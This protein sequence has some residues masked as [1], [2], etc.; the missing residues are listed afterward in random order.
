MKFYTKLVA[1]LLVT[2][3]LSACNKEENTELGSSST[4]SGEQKYVTAY[5][6]DSYDFAKKEQSGQYRVDLTDKVELS[7]NTEIKV[8]SLELLTSDSD[9][10][11]LSQDDSSF[12]ITTD[13][14]KVCDYEYFINSTDSNAELVGKISG[15]SRV[16]V[17]DDV[18]QAEL[19]PFGYVAYQGQEA[20]I[21]VEKELNK[22]G[23]FTDLDGYTLDTAVLSTSST[24]QVQL[25]T[26]NNIIEYTPAPGFLG[27]EPIMYSMKNANGD[28]LA[29]TVIA[30]VADEVKAG[31]DIQDTIV[32]KEPVLVSEST[33]V[34]L[35]PYVTNSDDDWQL[36]YVNSFDAMVNLTNPEDLQNKAFDFVAEHIGDFYVNAVVTDHHGGFDVSLIRLSVQ[37][38]NSAAT[39]NDIIQD[40][41]LFKAPL[42]LSEAQ[43]QG[44]IFASANADSVGASVAEFNFSQ[45]SQ[46]CQLVGRLPTE[47]EL[48]SFYTDS[49]PIQQGWPV[50]IPY[51]TSDI[52]TVVDLSTGVSKTSGNDFYYVTCIVEGGFE[53]LP[54][55]SSTDSIVA[56]GVDT[57]QVVA[58]LTSNGKPVEGQV[59]SA[60][61]NSDSAAQIE[62]VNV[63]TDADGKAYF[64][65]SDLKAETVSV[66]VAFNNSK[67]SMNVEFVADPATA[68]LSLDVI[69]DNQPVEGGVNQAKATLVDANENLVS[70]QAVH[71]TTNDP[72]AVVVQPTVNTDDFGEANADIGYAG[73][74][75]VENQSV[76]LTASY[77]NAD[78]PQQASQ[79]ITYTYTP[80]GDI[81]SFEQTGI[82]SNNQAIIEAVVKDADGIPVDD[83]FVH[84]V[85]TAGDCS[86]VDDDVRTDES[87]SA[88]NYVVRGTSEV[89]TVTASLDGHSY[90]HLS[91]LW[92]P[93]V[94]IVL[95]SA[96]GNSAVAGKCSYYG[97]PPLGTVG[98]LDDLEDWTRANI[99]TLKGSWQKESVKYGCDNTYYINI[100]GLTGYKETVGNWGPTCTAGYSKVLGVD[101]DSGSLRDLNMDVKSKLIICGR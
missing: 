88:I 20:K 2:F 13:N 100:F 15:I 34:D 99:K 83:I 16:V 54:E 81:V 89:C 31:I 53:I 73:E 58:K 25:D 90:T 50:D 47:S 93:Y 57:A 64:S 67:R 96:V 17:S 91:V 94:Q 75:L 51:W 7:A 49:K 45:A 61:V 28:V 63:T 36:I 43:S 18:E 23:D 22:V 78:F 80:S 84:F 71:F 35:T 97:Y 46:L 39:W 1:I 76:I 29:G 59:I 42:T 70:D 38:P 24:A 44:I 4:G 74:G 3:M 92:D 40:L 82:N 62:D 98:T 14:N 72:K 95:P 37:D 66:T 65:I 9:C 21:D 86:V 77:T 60:S 85:A 33:T 5:S 56:N 101:A 69:K 6:K 52:N 11:I 30:T 10:K 48:L 27:S 55:E 79:V 87:G 32:I 41:S 19:T 8:S 12:V 68:V 26:E